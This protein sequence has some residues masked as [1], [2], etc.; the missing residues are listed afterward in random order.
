[1]IVL[2]RAQRVG[3]ACTLEQP[4][5]DRA[6]LVSP[7]AYL[8]G[9]LHPLVVEEL[10]LHHRGYRVQ[11]VDPHLWC[12]FDDGTSLA[13]WNDTERSADAVRRLAP[14]DVE[15][16]IAYEALF[17]RIRASAQRTAHV[18]PGSANRR[19]APEIE[20]LVGHDQ[21]AIEVLFEESIASVVERHV[22]D[23]RLRTALHGQGIIGTNA[24]PR[25]PG[26]AAVHLMHSSGTLEGTE[27]AWGY[28]VGGMG[29][30][31]FA[32]ADAAEEAGAVLACGVPV[33]AVIPGVGV[34][35]E[36]GEMVRAKTV[37]SNADPK[38]TL[39]LIEADVP[40][41]WSSRVTGW[42]TASPVLKVNCALD[43][44]PTFTA[45]SPDA[46]PHRAMVTIS[47]G[48]DETQRVDEQSL[49]GE[50]CSIL[51]RAL[52][53]HGI[54]PVGRTTGPPRDEHLRPVRAS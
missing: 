5:E 52:F 43:R 16:F 53:P 54:R 25:D 33:A 41:G 42:R 29:R 48:S 9:L 34:R 6:Y 38:R 8:V 40:A 23:E 15:G 44:L 45:A 46:E 18:T 10:E 50:A 17:A 37:L 31:S 13:L 36:G 2:E 26:T 51:V 49:L 1:M 24:G 20:E 22:A 11:I 7:C 3:G 12:P 35:L 21:E 27:G 19:I 39:S 4:F 30:I 47:T 28:V 32:L 14:R